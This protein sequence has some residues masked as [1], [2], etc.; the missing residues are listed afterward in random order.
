MAMSP[1]GAF[2]A[3]DA[4]QM[5][6]SDFVLVDT[7]TRRAVLVRAPAPHTQIG[8][9]AWSADGDELTFIT[10]DRALYEGKASHVWRLRP[11]GASPSIDLLAL[12]PSVRK[13]VL[14]A[15]GQRLAA[16]EGVV[17]G[18]PPPSSPEL[19]FALYERSVIDGSAQRRSESQTQFASRLLYDRRNALFIQGFDPVFVGATKL[20]DGRTMHSWGHQDAAG[21]WSYQWNEERNA[22]SAFRLLPGEALPAWPTPF[23]DAHLPFG[24]HGMRL[25]NDG[26]MIVYA[27]LDP[28]N[29][30]ANGLI[31]WYAP[32]G[33]PRR[34]TR[35]MTY[36]YVAYDEEG[37]G[38]VLP[39]AQLP[40]NGARTG[41]A[42]ISEDGRYFAQV[43]SAHLQRGVHS[44]TEAWDDQSTFAFYDR[45]RLVFQARVADLIAGATVISPALEQT[46][47]MPVSDTVPHSASF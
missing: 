38:E 10:D 47:R 40:E 37:H 1:D 34:P 42:D 15:D 18:E 43:A 11:G 4:N 5:S 12:I 14:S 6:A 32:N 19:A 21:R 44:P 8:D 2:V 27:S 9:L 30:R 17:I 28:A 39:S 13:P 24:A 36:E 41:G 35:V 46:P 22:V 20:P 33:M 16:F 26:R 7:A 3:F 29:T 25:M 45:G 31:Q 23:P